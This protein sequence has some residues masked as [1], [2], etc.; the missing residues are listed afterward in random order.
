MKYAI[1]VSLNFLSTAA[2]RL[3]FEYFIT[4]PPRYF[5]RYTDMNMNKY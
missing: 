5:I 2:F 1:D 4:A 3:S